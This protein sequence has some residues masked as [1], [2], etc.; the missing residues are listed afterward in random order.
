MYMIADGAPQVPTY[1]GQ[2]S[3]AAFGRELDM[4]V[5]AA[6]DLAKG[7]AL[8]RARM[9]EAV[10]PAGRLAQPDE[11]SARI[12]NADLFSSD[13]RGDPNNAVF[14]ALHKQD[15][16]AYRRFREGGV[17]LGSDKAAPILRELLQRKRAGVSVRDQTRYVR[18]DRYFAE[19]SVLR[20]RDRQL[21]RVRRLR[22]DLQLPPDPSGFVPF[23]LPPHVAE[24]VAAS[25]K[26][27]NFEEYQYERTREFN[28][29]TRQEPHNVE[30]WLEFVRFQDESLVLN[31]KVRVVRRPCQRARGEANNSPFVCARVRSQNVSGAVVEK[32]IAILERAL[33][34]NPDS[35]VL[36]SQ[37]LQI[38]TRH[39]AAWRAHLRA[40][41]RSDPAA[42][43]LICP[44]RLSAPAAG[45]HA[46]PV[47]EDAYGAPDHP[48]AVARVRD[49]PPVAVLVVLHPRG[50]RSLRE[51]HPDALG[52]A[53]TRLPERL[54]LRRPGRAHGRA[55]GVGGGRG[56]DAA[57]RVHSRVLLRAA[58]PPAAAAL[59]LR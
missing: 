34:F 53:R 22:K 52:R 6:D 28:I 12:A 39:G 37:Y 58:G 48:A 43:S 25:V 14:E 2:S 35:E 32:K 41:H 4:E 33:Q 10:E 49:L 47:G 46:E 24:V 26:D 23:A 31:R 15:M 3:T 57:Q 5:I 16:P 29:R 36:L 20:E 56:G 19:K 50:A 40:Y 45:Q 44:H 59:A 30:T 21:Q 7:Q 18:H 38:C 11:N 8:E 1:G 27:Q 9:R 13:R 54:R 17:L 55:C 51:G 42:R